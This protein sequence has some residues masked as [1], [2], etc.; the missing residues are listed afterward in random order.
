V[1]R[2]GTS[3]RHH[4]QWLLALLAASATSGV[5]PAWAFPPYRST[6]AETAEPWTI[7]ARLGLLRYRLQAGENEWATPLA[8]VNFGFPHRLEL[9][10]EIEVLP[11]EKRV[12]DAAVGLKWVPYLRKLSVG[13]EALALLPV[14]HEGGAGVEA[15]ALFTAR[16]DPVLLHINAGGFFDARVA[17]REHGWEASLLCE[18]KLGRWH[19]GLE[20]A[21]WQPVPSPVRVLAGAGLIVDFGRVLLHAGVHAGLTAAA[22]D[23]V[24]SLWV[25]FILPVRARRE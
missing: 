23:V 21:A 19:P 14:S 13:V 17:P 20:V 7:E 5:S 8:R 25:S 12:G 6:D 1:R 22:P 15:Q 11:V 24:A 10:T 18:V 4:A 16:L 2:R 3:P 9:I